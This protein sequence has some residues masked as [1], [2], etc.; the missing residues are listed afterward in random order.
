MRKPVF[1]VSDLARHK[2][3]YWATERCQIADP[4]VASSIPARSHTFVDIDHEIF[5]TAIILPHTD[6]RRIVVSYK[7]KYVLEVVVNRLVNLAQEKK[8]GYVN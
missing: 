6:S 8:C 3:A 1:R 4:G 5:S 2:P 7:R